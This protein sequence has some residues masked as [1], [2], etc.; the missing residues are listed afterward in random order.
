MEIKKILPL[1]GRYLENLKR[2]GV[3]NDKAGTVLFV[4]ICLYYEDDDALSIFDDDGQSRAALLVYK[5]LEFKGLIEQGEVGYHITLITKSLIDDIIADVKKDEV[6]EIK[7][8]LKPDEDFEWIEDYLDL[9]PARAM[10]G[11]FLKGD[12]KNIYKKMQKFMTEYEFT[13]DEIFEATKTYLK[14]REAEDFNYT[15]K[16]SNFIFH[17]EV[18]MGH[19][20]SSELAAWCEH[21]KDKKDKPKPQRVEAF[22]DFL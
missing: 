6:V 18:A 17:R 13:K 16:V 19:N 12:K 22:D 11:Y 3:S 20:I 21:L 2:L 1:V 10:Q 9:W 8:I 15:K 7:P 5:D 14:E 4:L